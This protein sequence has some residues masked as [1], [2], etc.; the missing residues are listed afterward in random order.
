MLGAIGAALAVGVRRAGLLTVLI[1]TRFMCRSS[2]SAP[3]HW[4]GH[5][6]HRYVDVAAIA[7]LGLISA[8]SIFLAPPA[9]AAALRAGL[10]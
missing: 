2:C 4:R 9:I 6:R 8:A 1:V 7:V 10:R 3:V 5:S